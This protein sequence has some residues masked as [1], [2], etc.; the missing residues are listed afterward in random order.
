[1]SESEQ[2]Q[3]QG[4][5]QEVRAQHLS[6]RIP[7]G[8]SPGVFS[9]GA[10][11]M[12]G[13]TEFILDFVQNIGRPHQVVARIVMPHAVMPQFIEALKKNIDIYKQR[14]GPP[15]EMPKPPKQ[16][17][18]RRLTPQEIYDD[19]KLPDEILSGAYANGVMIGHSAAEFNMDFLTNF[20]P[21][22]A[23]SKR[24]FMSAAQVPR[25]LDS[26]SGTFNQF[27]QRVQQQQAGQQA[28]P[29][30]GP[31]QNPQE[32]PPPPPTL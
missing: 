2:P 26:L 9:T 27:Q 19:L 30:P 7:D 12:T 24:V 22:S 21:N 23:V 4:N 11:V 1:M 32:D 6:A 25:L 13:G 14:F 3:D 8:V 15:P 5:T 17:Q 29:P 16:Q 18:Q 10:I 31:Q 20:F 28:P